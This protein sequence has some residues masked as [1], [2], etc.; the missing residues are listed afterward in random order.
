MNSMVGQLSRISTLVVLL[1]FPL[2]GQ[3]AAK[4][5]AEAVKS[6]KQKNPDIP[7]DPKGYAWKLLQDAATG[8]KTS[9]RAIAVRVMGLIPANAK[10]RGMAERALKDEKPEVR[11]AA[12]FALGEARS[13]ASIPKIKGLLSDKEPSVAIAAAHALELMHDEDGTDSIMKSSRESARRGR[14]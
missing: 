7:A 3:E 13:T 11:T 9:E 12:A 5:A 8:D 14:A 4:P 2:A 6:E 1:S 10:A